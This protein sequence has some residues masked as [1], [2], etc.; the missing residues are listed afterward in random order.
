ML[1]GRLGE[2]PPRR[3]RPHVLAEQPTRDRRRLAAGAGPQD[4]LR[5]GALRPLRAH[6]RRRLLRADLRRTGER[7]LGERP[8]RR[9]RELLRSEVRRTTDAVIVRILLCRYAP[10]VLEGCSRKSAKKVS[11]YWGH[12][13]NKLRLALPD[14]S[15]WQTGGGLYTFLPPPR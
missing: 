15:V 14:A 4:R 11:I 13:T 9:R 2:R 3:S 6:A 8:L 5:H 7:R 10:Y 12:T 1:P